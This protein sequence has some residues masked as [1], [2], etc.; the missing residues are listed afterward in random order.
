[1][2]VELKA[3]Q[4]TGDDVKLYT[5]AFENQRGMHDVNGKFFVY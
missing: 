4:M 5:A 2:L 1:M 3:L